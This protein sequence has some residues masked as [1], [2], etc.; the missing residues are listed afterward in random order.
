MHPSRE[1]PSAALPL[2]QLPFP[3]PARYLRAQTWFLCDLSLPGDSELI[4]P[5]LLLLVL[6]N[7]C[8]LGA[9]VVVKRLVLCL[10]LAWVTGW[11]W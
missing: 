4:L 1:S 11:V 2:P 10:A 5:L 6:A 3:A 9:L 7:L 8:L